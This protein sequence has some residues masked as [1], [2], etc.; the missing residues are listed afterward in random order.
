MCSGICPPSNPAGT[1][2]RALVPLVP[3]PAVLPRLPP[4][5]RPT[6]ILALLAPG[7]G[8]RWCT[9]RVRACSGVCLDSAISVHLLDGDQV[10]HGRDHAADLGAVLTHDA[11]ADTAE[12]E[13]AQRLALVLLAT[14]RGLGLRDLQLCH[15]APTFPADSAC[16]SSR[17]L[18]SPSARLRSMTAGATRSSGRPRRAATASGCSRLRSA[19]AVAWTMLIAFSEPSDLLSTSWIPAQSRTART[20]PPAMTPVPGAAGRRKTTPAAASPVTACGI[21]FWIIG[22]R[23]KFFFASSTPFAIAAGT[24]FALP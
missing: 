2:L 12:A 24:S 11:A 4:S 8:R 22:T 16:F 7:A 1:W 5:P 17:A 20:G 6:R 23:K 9:L 10:S 14:D 18:A 21:V 3:R 13:R 15:H 19:C